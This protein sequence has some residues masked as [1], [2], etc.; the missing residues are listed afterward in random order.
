[1]I[2][3]VDWTAMIRGF[4]VN[5]LCVEALHLFAQMEG[6]GKVFLQPWRFS[7]SRISS[8]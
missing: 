6:E 7:K 1:M 3:S 5:C 4:A 8:F 2:Y